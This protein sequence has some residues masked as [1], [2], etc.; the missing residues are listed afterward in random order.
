MHRS[1]GTL[2]AHNIRKSYGD[3]VVLAG[4]SLSVTPASR[5]AELGVTADT[6]ATPLIACVAASPS[7]NGQYTS[8]PAARKQIGASA[9]AVTTRATL[10]AVSGTV[11]TAMW[12]ACEERYGFTYAVLTVV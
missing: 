12:G 4:L 3:T 6:P 9:S 11:Q 8:R 2:A 10:P 5:T 1:R 7:S